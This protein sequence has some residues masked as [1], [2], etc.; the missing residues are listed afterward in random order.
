MV[1]EFSQSVLLREGQVVS[2]TFESGSEH[3]PKLFLGSP[4][5]K[6][7]AILVSSQHPLLLDFGISCL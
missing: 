7:L 2:V 3:W 6:P 1:E 4:E 5:Y